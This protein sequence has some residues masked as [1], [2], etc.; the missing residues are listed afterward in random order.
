MHIQVGGSTEWYSVLRR[1]FGPP[2]T[3][4]LSGLYKFEKILELFKEDPSGRYVQAVNVMYNVP[5]GCNG[6]N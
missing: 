5:I 1:L 2:Y 4:S 6:E 3:L